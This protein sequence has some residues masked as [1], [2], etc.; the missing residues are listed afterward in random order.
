MGYR[1]DGVV[2]DLS[3]LILYLSSVSLENT[4]SVFFWHTSFDSPVI[5]ISSSTGW[6]TLL[7]VCGLRDSPNR[8][9][10]IALFVRNEATS[11]FMIWW[12]SSLS[13]PLSRCGCKIGG[14][15]PARRGARVTF[16]FVFKPDKSFCSSGPLGRLSTVKAA[17]KYK[18]ACFFLLRIRCGRFQLSERDP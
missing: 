14:G 7:N 4:R 1:S 10:R 16:V 15:G 11:T 17:L 6:S 9:T 5:S 13:F 18:N 2:D 8:R 3:N 12:D